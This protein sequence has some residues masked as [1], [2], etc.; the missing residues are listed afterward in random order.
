[1]VELD[2][3]MNRLRFRVEVENAIGSRANFEDVY[4]RQVRMPWRASI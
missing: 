2:R 1:M 4:K 3:E